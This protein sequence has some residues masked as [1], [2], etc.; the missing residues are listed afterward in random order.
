MSFVSFEKTRK[1]KPIPW[2]SIDQKVNKC[3][4]LVLPWKTQATPDGNRGDDTAPDGA[5]TDQIWQA[6]ADQIY[7][8]VA[9]CG[10]FL[11]Y[12]LS[13]IVKE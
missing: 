10:R 4:F 12:F 7:Q 11:K 6:V 5:R 8:A 13:R 2:K 3:T 9:G 1:S